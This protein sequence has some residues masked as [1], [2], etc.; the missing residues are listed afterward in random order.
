MTVNSLFQPEGDCVNGLFQPE[1]GCVNL[2]IEETVKVENLKP[3]SARVYAYYKPGAFFFFC[4][5]VCV[6]VCVCV[7]V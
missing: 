2:V 6:Y 1:D 3:G 4:V 5:C 7:C